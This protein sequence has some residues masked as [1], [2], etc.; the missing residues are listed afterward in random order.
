MRNR[1]P[2]QMP[3]SSPPAAARTSMITS[4]SS[5]GSRGTSMRRSRLLQ[6]RR[7]RPRGRGP[8]SPTP[9]P[10]PGRPRQPPVRGLRRRRA[11]AARNGVEGLGH[12]LQ[13]GVAP[14]GLG[15][16]GVVGQ[17]LGV[18]QDL[19]RVL[20]RPAD[21]L[22]A[23]EEGGVHQVYS[24]SRAPATM[25]PRPST[26]SRSA[27]SSEAS[28]LVD[29]HLHLVVLGLAGGQGLQPQAGDGQEAQPAAVGADLEHLV[30][31][32]GD[33]RDPQRPGW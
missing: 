11:S 30:G 14:G 27:G 20:Q 29:R 16:A 23:G 18:G 24:A 26:P 4:F 33:H 8:C 25:G 2:A 12:R 32:A 31:E 15:V 10:S 6:W 9:P 19:Q 7:R 1:S 21:L 28:R 5:L 3:A 13:L 17:H 22:Q